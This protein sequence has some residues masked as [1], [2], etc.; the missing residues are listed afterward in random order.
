MSEDEKEY[1]E[2]TDADI[3]TEGEHGENSICLVWLC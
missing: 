1:D 2:E 3:N